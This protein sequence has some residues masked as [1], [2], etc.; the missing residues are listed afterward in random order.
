MIGT[1]REARWHRSPNAGWPEAATAHALGITLAGPRQ[2]DSV[3]IDA[4]YFNAGGHRT[5]DESDIR[6]AL[7]Q[8]IAVL[9]LHWLIYLGLYAALA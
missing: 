6:R 2:Y 3:K 1:V 9:I 5:V 4:P 8:M 7:R